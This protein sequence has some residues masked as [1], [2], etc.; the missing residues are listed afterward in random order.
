MNKTL[1]TIF[2]WLSLALLS[3]IVAIQLYGFIISGGWALTQSE[4]FNRFGWNSYT[5]GLISRFAVL[6][7]GIFWIFYISFIES[8]IHRWQKAEKLKEK[9]LKTAGYLILSAVLLYGLGFLVNLG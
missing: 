4:S 8:F 3:G 2:A 9:F 1:A 7:A 6:V 5:I